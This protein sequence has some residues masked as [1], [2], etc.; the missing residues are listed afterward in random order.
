MKILIYS[1]N[2]SPELTGIGKYSGEMASWLSSKGHDVRVVTAPPYYPD[3]KVANGFRSTRYLTELVGGLKIFRCPLWVPA[4]PSGMKRL[5]HLLSFAISSSPIMLRQVFWRPDIVWV[6]EPTF[7]CAPCAWVVARVCRAK[8][9]LHI[10]DFEVDAAF[11]LGL[12]KGIFLKSTISFVEGRLLR[13]FDIVSTISHRML[14][15]LSF[16]GVSVDKSTLFPNWVDI[17]KITPGFQGY[18]FRNELNIPASSLVALYSGNMGAKQGLDILS[19][20]ASL[21]RDDRDLYF[22]FC[23][24]GAGRTDLENSCK[25]LNNV[26]FIDLQPPDRLSELLAT[27]DIHLLPQRADV[28]DLVMP[29]KLTGMLAS[30]RPI[31]ATA[32]FGTEVARVVE[33]LGVVVQPE[34]PK[35]FAQAISYLCEN[36]SLRKDFGVAARVYAENYLDKDAVLK[37]FEEKLMQLNFGK[38]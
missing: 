7:F 9:W 4:K 25:G 23:G 20:A 28:A 36:A 16:K 11:D 27:A 14:D 29:S 33:G 8:A 37:L 31:V 22:I 12:L 32:R 2:F 19:E 34:D 10:Q 1:L 3:W 26:R 6:V 15:R 38:N 30:G 21:L 13:N 5:L 17:S 24:N 18:A 35:A